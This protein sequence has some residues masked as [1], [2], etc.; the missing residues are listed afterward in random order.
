MRTTI[1]LGALVRRRVGAWCRAGLPTAAVVSIGL[2]VAWDTLRTGAPSSIWVAEAGDLLVDGRASRPVT[3]W[4]AVTWRSTRI[5]GDEPWPWSL[6]RTRRVWCPLHPL[7]RMLGLRA[8]HQL[9][10]YTGTEEVRVLGQRNCRLYER[11]GV[12]RG[13]MWP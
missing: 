12:L 9:A 2:V 7:A 4:D 1:L 13:W 10:L 6:T 8:P 11:D 3:Q 5:W